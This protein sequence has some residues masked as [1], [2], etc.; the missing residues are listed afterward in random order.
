M[1]TGLQ[2]K[3][4]LRCSVCGR[5]AYFFSHTG[6]LCREDALVDAVENGWM[7]A[8]IKLTYPGGR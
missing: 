4:D 7:P 1:K 5:R 8:P 2:E 3:S 6:L